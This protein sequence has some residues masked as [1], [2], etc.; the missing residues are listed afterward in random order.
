MITERQFA[1]SRFQHCSTIS[2]GPPGAGTFLAYY[3]GFAEMHQSQHVKIHWFSEDGREAEPIEL[4][5]YTGNPIL[6][7]TLA[8]T[9]IIYSKFETLVPNRIEWWQHCSLWNS[10]L[11]IKWE[12]GKPK[13]IVGAPKQIIVDEPGDDP[14]PQGLGYLPRCHPIIG[15]Q[16]EYLLPLYREH[17]P[18]F[19]GTVLS[20]KDGIDWEYHSTI[21]R[22]VRCIQPTIFVNQLGEICALLRNFTRSS[23]PYA[24]YSKLDYDKKT[25]SK[26]IHSPYFNANNSILAITHA[27]EPFIIWNNDSSGRDKI[28]LGNFSLSKPRLIAQLDGYG[29][30]P[31]AC[32][33]VI[34]NKLHIVYT[35]RPNFLKTPNVKFA[36]KWKTY[37]LSA[38]LN[39]VKARSISINSLRT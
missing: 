10:S 24:Y 7:E 1:P 25:W 9:R 31:A 20:S 19:H 39:N 15:P 6:F 26:P 3:T 30:Y 13:I 8:G 16:G 4:G 21:G 5:D 23:K 34:N 17:E 22:G 12:H 18:H 38:V 29:S 28:S 33:D 36:I 11:D 27:A 14:P 37:D 35:A 2:K 32:T